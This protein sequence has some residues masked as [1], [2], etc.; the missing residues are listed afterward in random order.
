MGGCTLRRDMRAF[1]ETQTAVV[2]VRLAHEYSMETV[3]LSH[4]KRP[5]STSTFGCVLWGQGLFAS[6]V[7]VID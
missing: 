6:E 1:E 3:T 7:V 2:L 4:T 5:H